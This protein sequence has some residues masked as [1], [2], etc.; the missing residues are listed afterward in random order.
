MTHHHSPP[1]SS[2]P[3]PCSP[4][5]PSS[6]SPAPPPHLL[7]G[8]VRQPSHLDDARVAAALSSRMALRP[9]LP[10]TAPALPPATPRM[11]TIWEG[12]GGEEGGE[13]EGVEER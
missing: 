5:L 13:R 10:A 4:S 6:V 1:P 12:G 11:T 8:G 3:F 2:P 9:V 7:G